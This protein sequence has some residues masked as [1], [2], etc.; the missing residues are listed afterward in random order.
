[1]TF[2]IPTN[3]K[4]YDGKKELEKILNEVPKQ[5]TPKE[6]KNTVNP[7]SIQEHDKYEYFFAGENE[8]NLYKS[9]VEKY[10]YKKQKNGLQTLDDLA[11][12][13]LKDK[14]LKGSSSIIN[15][16]MN[17][18][19]RENNSNVYVVTQ[20]QLEYVFQNSLL[21]L[22]DK[23]SDT[24]MCLR[25]DSGNNE[26]LAKN[27][28]KQLGTSINLPVYIP[29][30]S[31]DLVKDT[32]NNLGFKIVDLAKI[33]NLPILN[34][35]NGKFDNSY[36]DLL[37]GFPKQL[38]ENGSR[39]FWTTNSGLSGCYLYTDSNLN[40]YNS[41]LSNSNDDGRVVLAKVRST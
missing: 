14:L 10:F 12:P 25:S 13:E 40:S 6:D 34:S 31:C 27:L 19:L 20:A 24:G 18:A 3:F 5:E 41:V 36:V 28:V 26:N 23:Y 21:D 7:I 38:N 32:N 37:I 22:K 15:S 35:P 9:F 39:N 2:K 16:A 4:G 1:M 8:Y 29:V 30:I 11:K 17:M 33:I